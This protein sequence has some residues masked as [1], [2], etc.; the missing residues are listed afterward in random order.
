[1]FK[2]FKKKKK[3]QLPSVEKL[4]EDYDVVIHIGAPKAGSSAI[5]KYLLENSSKLL[6]LGFYYPD[7][8]LDENGISCGHS[9]LGKNLSDGDYATAAA[10]MQT[11]VAEAKQHNCTLLISTESLFDKAETLKKILGNYRCKIIAFYREPLESLYSNYNQG[12]KRNYLTTRLEAFCQSNIDKPDDFL[13]GQ[14]FE[15]W[16]VAFGKQHITVVGYDTELFSQTPIQ[17]VF[18]SLIGIDAISQKQHFIFNTHYVNNSYCLAALELKRMF[19]FVLDKTQSKL[20]H[21]ID[22]FLQGISD[23][24]NKTKYQLADRITTETYE[25]LKNKFSAS[26]L[27]IREDLLLALN[28][29]FLNEDKK[30][31][32][33]T[34]NQ[35][36]LSAEMID[37]LTQL[38][39]QKPHLY[40]YIQQQIDTFLLNKTQHY[41]IIKLAEMFNFDL[42]QIEI[43]EAWFNQNQLKNIPNLQP[44]EIY[45]DI[46]YL[47]YHRGDLTNAQLLI[48]KAREIRPNGPAIVK[49]S[50]LI[51][52]RLN[53][54]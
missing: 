2:L 53:A 21:Q 14:V 23:K 5:Q 46:A 50:E 26:T 33:K 17:S 41:E 47:C 44:V 16:A 38:N 3:I 13:S 22:W 37:L 6:A 34:V 24:S 1:M 4:S 49:L 35:A 11:Y 29:N 43:K 32:P 48:E 51:T 39:Q 9:I 15:H 54:K 40:R 8:G 20:N 31:K 7:H 27:K 19:N 36:K 30:S 25:Q 42:N 12:I 28:P 10:I 45:R 52:Q 18:L